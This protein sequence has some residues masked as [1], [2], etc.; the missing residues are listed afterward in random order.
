MVA[1]TWKL[2]L[3]RLLK[4]SQT[5]VVYTEY[6]MKPVPTPVAFRR[7]LSSEGTS[8]LVTYCVDQVLIN[9]K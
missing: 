8:S 4:V 7:I 5:E 2:C 3:R 6:F 9:V 1:G